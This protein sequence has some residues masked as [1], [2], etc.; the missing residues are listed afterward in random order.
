MA[1]HLFVY[2]TLRKGQSGERAREL[3]AHCRWLGAA[4]MPGRLYAVA[5]TYPG[6]VTTQDP[7]DVVKGELYELD[8]P[9]R[10]LKH[11]DEYEGLEYSRQ[12]GEAYLPDGTPIECWVY[13]WTGEVEEETHIAS[14]DFLAR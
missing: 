4:E 6:M 7:E 9:E 5:P 11:I 14:G 8:H 3:E 12:R 13:V 1:E 10:R 2:G